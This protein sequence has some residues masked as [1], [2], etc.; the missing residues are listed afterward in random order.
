M[1]A[2]L[3]IASFCLATCA[4]ISSSVVAIPAA[5]AV[6]STATPA[7]VTGV[8]E[9]QPPALATATTEASGSGKL[10]SASS[11]VQKIIQEKKES[12]SSFFG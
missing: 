8:V 12:L 2:R 9:L 7:A 11:Q 3:L 5:I 1:S 4:W 10:A 6:E